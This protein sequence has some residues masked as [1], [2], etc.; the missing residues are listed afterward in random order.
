MDTKQL[1]DALNELFDEKN[2]RVIFWNDPGQ[3]FLSI[4]DDQSLALA[5]GVELIR[6]DQ[7]GAFESK[8]R[9]ECDEPETKFLV[10]APTEEPAYEDDWL[11]DIRLYSHSFRADKASIILDELGLNNQHLR[12]HIALRRKFFDSKERV[13]K[14]KNH[15]MPD[16]NAADLDRKM[17]T[18]VT[19]GDQPELFNTVRTLFHALSAES[20]LDINQPPAVW[21]QIEKYDL[22]APFWQMV[23]TE[24][25]Y[26]EET[27]S[28][29]NLLVRLFVADFT[30]HLESD[31]PEAL[32]NLQ[33]PPAGRSNAVVCLAQWRD[34]SSKARSYDILS[35][36]VAEEIHL[37]SHLEGKG[38]S[39]LMDVMTFQAV[40][41]AICRNLRDRVKATTETINAEDIRQIASRRQ[42]G[43]WVSLSVPGAD[44]V[45]RRAWR[46]V[47][48]ALVYAADFFELRNRHQDG[49]AYDDASAMYHGYEEQL[50]RF[51]QLYRHFC[52]AADIVEAQSWDVLK[53][54]REQVETCYVNWFTTS[55]AL[56]WGKFI[57]SGLLKEWRIDHVPLQHR[58]FKNHVQ[59]RLDEAENRK[60]F[61]ILSDALRYEA[62]EELARELNGKYR[63]K[64]ELGSQLGVLPSYTRLGMA[65]L[66][67]HETLAYNGKG[68]VL[69]DGKPTISSDQ[70]EVI[71]APFDGLVVGAN[72]LLA[73]KK[74]EGRE[75]VS[76]K[77]VVYIYHDHID[78]I[79]DDR[80]TEGETFDA[81]RKAIDEL[82]DLVRYVVNSLNGNYVV[83]TADHGFL[84]TETKP[85]ETDKSKLS[86]KPPGTI[87][88][89]KRYLVGKDL[90]D[91]DEVWHGD[92]AITADA[93]GGMEFW[94]P[95]GTNRFH[96][97]GGA[98]F[99]HGGAMLQEVV[100]PVITIRHKKGKSAQETKTK[101]VTIHVLGT[102]HKITTPRHRFELIQVEA[103]GERIKPV[104]LKVAIYEGS[105]P[106]TN[107]EAVTF[108][109]T[110]DNMEGRKKSIIL[111]LRDRSY[112]KATKYRLILRDADTDIEQQS[113]DVIIDRAFRDDF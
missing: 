73:M 87:V 18:V 27:P 1:N 20:E 49:F 48:N 10:Y 55:L 85:A 83:V 82:G 79:G 89:K 17:L 26:S 21:E 108:D 60:A 22:D 14:L 109:S 72:E 67:P 19:K 5:D 58:F 69:L 13:A 90:G 39:E 42:A 33:L 25:G 38:V 30:Q 64:A 66:L 45:P 56:C 81:V 11:L 70:R 61:V 62:A 95:K 104:T 107:I 15:V 84:F 7:A 54:V 99:I 35:E 86:D 110:S 103:V 93:E 46:A 23:K 24:F 2:H 47:Y 44:L 92:T 88:A 8:I 102:T 106:V 50:F 16:D 105:E 91:S 41:K 31:M 3:D 29:G 94:I 43:H 111:V 36:E 78:A 51:D 34:S 57:D 9:M 97:M 77:R 112:D 53:D 52:E 28:L 32:L 101:Q 76:G 6:L 100:V 74:E 75:L 80:K 59:P 68:E 98:R 71:L 63:I 40:E 37:S 65:S 12:S 4:I 113:V 96:F